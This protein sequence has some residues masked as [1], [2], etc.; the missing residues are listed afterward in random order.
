MHDTADFR[1][2]K[3]ALPT[4]DMI[5]A[6]SR[7]QW[8]DGQ[9]D[10]G[11]TTREL[12]R[13]AAELTGKEAA[14]FCVTGT[15]ANQL[16]IMT[17]TRPGDTILLDEI[18]HTFWVEGGGP[19]ALAGAQTHALRST[20]G[21]MAL[22]AMALACDRVHAGARVTLLCTENTHNFA[23]GRV[24]PVDYLESVRDLAHSHGAK[25][26]L[27]G[28]RITN[29]SVASGVPVA[30]YAET[31]DSL[32][33]CLSKGLCAPVGSV[34]CGDEETIARARHLMH[35]FGGQPKQPGPLAACGVIALATMV[36]RLAEDH[37]NAA[38]LAEGLGKLPG[39]DAKLVVEAPETNMVFMT[40]IDGDADVFI[41]TL[42]A[43]GVHGYHIECGRMRFVTHRDVDA[44]DVDRA[45]EVFRDVLLG[46]GA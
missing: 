27:D 17:H 21:M 37:D 22:D 11:E 26:H 7:S 38:R 23:G 40:L 28:A 33:F 20:D 2:D 8:G 46:K 29:A 12:E 30:R 15:M 18:S 19:A 25:V 45:V 6:M 14:L 34:L 4:H 32:M 10:L 35:R 43:R 9:D 39:I 13:R 3:C 16:A 36:D 5:A 1:S 31:A 42:A 41:E 24:V 44:E